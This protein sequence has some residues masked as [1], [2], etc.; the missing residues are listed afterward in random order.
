MSRVLSRDF[1]MDGQ[2]IKKDQQ[3]LLYQPSK[4][5]V[6]SGLYSFTFLFGMGRS[7]ACIAKSLVNILALF[8]F[9]NPVSRRSKI[10]R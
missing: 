7:G 6:S 5:S 4:Q 1:A 10:K 2:E 3:T 8:T 9:L